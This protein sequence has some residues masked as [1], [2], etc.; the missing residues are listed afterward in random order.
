MNGLE[1]YRSII[2]QREAMQIGHAHRKVRYGKV[3]SSVG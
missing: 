2:L 3:M 1:K